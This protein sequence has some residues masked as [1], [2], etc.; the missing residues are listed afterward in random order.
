MWQ[1]GK[2]AYKHKFCRELAGECMGKIIGSSLVW[3]NF[4]FK[5]GEKAFVSRWHSSI[6]SPK[7]FGR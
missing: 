7:M 4:R 6:K 1:E 3:L 5:K 2:K